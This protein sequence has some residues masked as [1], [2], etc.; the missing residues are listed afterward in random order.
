[1]ACF[2]EKTKEKSLKGA[3]RKEIALWAILAKEPVSGPEDRLTISTVALSQFLHHFKL[4]SFQRYSAGIKECSHIFAG[5]F[6][7]YHLDRTVSVI[8]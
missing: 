4:F 8:Y 7:I 1:M 2:R 5:G 3:E 6:D